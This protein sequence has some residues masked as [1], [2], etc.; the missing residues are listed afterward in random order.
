MNRAR[1]SRT[2]LVGKGYTEATY[3]H[4]GYQV[5]PRNLGEDL[6]ILDLPLAASGSPGIAGNSPFSGSGTIMVNRFI[7]SPLEA[8]GYD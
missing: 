2:A 8:K 7:A 6:I 4:Y 1:Q 5:H 3:V